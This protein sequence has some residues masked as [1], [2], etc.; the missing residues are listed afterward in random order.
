MADWRTGPAV[1]ALLIAIHFVAAQHWPSLRAVT[2]LLLLGVAFA[3]YQGGVRSGAL[4][5]AM[6]FLYLTYDYSGASFFEYDRIDIER[7][8]SL[9]L[10]IPG[11]IGLVQ[12][13]RLRLVENELESIRS[14]QLVSS[15]IAHDLRGAAIPIIRYAEILKAEPGRPLSDEDALYLERLRHNAL[16]LERLIQEL[17]RIT[18]AYEER[19]RG[20]M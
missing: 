18:A 6:A 12:S 7:M 8:I 3:A 1:M 15:R 14:L 9:T 5:G 19:S 20:K 10:V 2:S 11:I 16:Q 17:L 4:A 13:L